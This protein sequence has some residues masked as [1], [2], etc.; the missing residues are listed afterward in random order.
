MIGERFRVH[1]RDRRQPHQA[2]IAQRVGGEQLAR[3]RETEILLGG[4]QHQA[5]IVEVGHGPHVRAQAR[6]RE[7][8]LPQVAVAQQRLARQRFG[9]R[10][11]EPARGGRRTDDDDRRLLEEPLGLESGP[12]TLALPNS[13]METLALQVDRAKRRID[14]ERQR[15]MTVAP[16]THARQQPAVRERRQYRDAQAL[17]LAARCCGGRLHA[18]VEQRQRRLHAAQQRL[19]R[20]IEDDAA[21]ATLEQ[22]EAQLLLEP[23]DLLAHRAVRQVQH[24]ACCAQVLQLGHRAKCGK[25]V[26][27]QAGRVGHGRLR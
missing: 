2:S 23:A 4:L 8:I 15:R 12:R 27:R 16:A 13:G 17:R 10:A 19:T 1:D 11:Q 18:I 5:R 6:G 21:A 7:P 20:R 25:R 14:L 22:R 9:L 3:Q 26:E 24:L